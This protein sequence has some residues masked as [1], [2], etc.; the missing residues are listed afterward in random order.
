M[1]EAR[2]QGP[3]FPPHIVF[4]Q[5]HTI[6]TQSHL[7]TP[8]PQL[9]PKFPVRKIRL[10]TLSSTTFRRHS[11]GQSLVVALLHA[12]QLVESGESL[13]GGY[14]VELSPDSVTRT[15]EIDQEG[16]A[17][18]PAHQWESFDGGAGPQIGGAARSEQV[19]DQRVVGETPLERAVDEDESDVI[20]S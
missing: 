3:I 19:A 16:D 2:I 4:P 17:V 9:L 10:H 1:N 20:A 14:R 7:P 15:G 12:L 18:G 6:L 8:L 13:H 5:F 11:Y